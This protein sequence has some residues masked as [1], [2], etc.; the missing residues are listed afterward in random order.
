MTTSLMF[1]LTHTCLDSQ[2]QKIVAITQPINQEIF[3]FASLVQATVTSHKEKSLR[4]K[5]NEKENRRHEKERDATITTE[6]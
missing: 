2:L 5:K 3:Y 4:K 6:A 1:K